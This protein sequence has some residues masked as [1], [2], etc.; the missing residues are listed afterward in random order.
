[1]Q[2]EQLE[3]FNSL[4]VNAR[5]L[6]RVLGLVRPSTFDPSWLCSNARASFMMAVAGLFR[7]LQNYYAS[8][9]DLWKRVEKDTNDNGIG[10]VRHGL[11]RIKSDSDFNE[12]RSDDSATEEEKS[13]ARK[14]LEAV[15][16]LLDFTAGV[17]DQSKE[18]RLQ[19]VKKNYTALCDAMDI[20]KGG[21]GNGNSWKI[22]LDVS[23][24]FETVVDH[25]NTTLLAGDKS[26]SKIIKSEFAKLKQ[27]CIFVCGAPTVFK[28]LC[29]VPGVLLF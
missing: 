7:D 23:A 27:V 11:A 10:L 13:C 5:T 14:M 4:F 6:H 3:D 24:N 28:H 20:Q 29:H 21:L 1:M 8:D 2:Q 12:L 25:A 26:K 16:S 19:L 9:K 22:D 18:I 15:Q 17:I